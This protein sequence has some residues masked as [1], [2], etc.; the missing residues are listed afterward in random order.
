MRTLILMRKPDFHRYLE[1]LMT[2]DMTK[3]RKYCLRRVMMKPSVP[4]VL[5]LANLLVT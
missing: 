2:V 5:L 3:M 1:G 4:L